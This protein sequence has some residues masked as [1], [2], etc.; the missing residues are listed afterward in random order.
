[1]KTLAFHYRKTIIAALIGALAGYA[2][3]ALIGCSGGSCMISSNPYISTIYGLAMG[4]LAVGVP[5]T[6]K[7]KQVIS[8]E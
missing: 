7:S 5:E 8:H 3:Y 2:Y 4:V 1:M 6:K